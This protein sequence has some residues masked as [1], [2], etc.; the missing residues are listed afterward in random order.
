MGIE[1]RADEMEDTFSRSRTRRIP[2]IRSFLILFFC[3]SSDIFTS[4][5]SSFAWF[6]RDSRD[7]LVRDG[8]DTKRRLFYYFVWNVREIERSRCR[9]FG[10]HPNVQNYEMRTAKEA[11]KLA[12][13]S[14]KGMCR[15]DA[16]L[17]ERK[18]AER[19]LLCLSNWKMSTDGSTITKEFVAKDF[20][21]A[22]DF[23]R[24]VTVVAEEEGHHPDLSLSRYRNVRLDLTTHSVGGL[25][26]ADMIMAAKIDLL[27]VMYSKKWMESRRDNEE[28]R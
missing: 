10:D 18:E 14:C 22:M 2:S 4:R 28:G 26:E 3:N 7:W 20:V 19:T 17:L 6:L 1:P 24:S 27:P 21:S 11:A 13:K 16:K 8:M 25:T 12:S 9:S 23:F 5:A 15:K